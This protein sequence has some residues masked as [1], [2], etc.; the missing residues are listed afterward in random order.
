[1]LNLYAC[2]AGNTRVAERFPRQQYNVDDPRARVERSS[3]RTGGPGDAGGVGQG[4]DVPAERAVRAGHTVRHGAHAVRG[5]S[6]SRLLRRPVHQSSQ[7]LRPSAAL[8]P[9]DQR[10]NRS[11]TKHFLSKILFLKK[12]TGH[13]LLKC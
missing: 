5:P 7:V 8:L 13:L 6:T 4:Q 1:M 3:C 12:M 11:G 9:H 2:V 10:Q